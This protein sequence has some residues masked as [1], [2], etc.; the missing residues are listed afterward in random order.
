MCLTT[1]GSPH[2]RVNPGDGCSYMP[3][4]RRLPAPMIT[5]I[6]RNA[7]PPKID[8]FSPITLGLPRLLHRERTEGTDLSSSQTTRRRYMPVT[9]KRGSRSTP[10]NKKNKTVKFKKVF[11]SQV[12][13]IAHTSAENNP[14]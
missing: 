7:R 5:Q 6:G 13:A 10:A 3:K 1:L 11:R 2:P 12:A 14:S 4:S 9:K 8:N